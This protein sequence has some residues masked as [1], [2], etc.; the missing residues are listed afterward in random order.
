MNRVPMRT[1]G[2]DDVERCIEIWTAAC[3][4]RDGQAFPGVADRA[5]PKFDSSIAFFVTGGR[6]RVDGFVLATRP[7]SG[8]AAD[9]EDAAV[10]G[11][12]AVDPSLHGEGRGRALLRA[13]T[14]RL[15]ELGHEQAVLH[16]LLDNTGA[17][18]LYESEGWLAQGSAYEHSLLKRPLRTFA[19]SLLPD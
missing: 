9:P 7:G 15:S 2:P 11:L 8:M 6:E 18:Q 5:R 12:L 3:A 16:A 4:A 17:I 10:V 1:G 14:D 19:R 13:V